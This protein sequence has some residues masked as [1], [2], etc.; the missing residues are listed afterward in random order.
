VV[1]KEHE[2]TLKALK[3]NVILCKHISKERR[4]THRSSFDDVTF[5]DV[6]EIL[7]KDLR[8]KLHI[9]C[10]SD[11]KLLFFEFRDTRK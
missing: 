6:V 1:L 2:T 3:N 4:L 8:N 11:N 5:S 7:L 9:F 10:D